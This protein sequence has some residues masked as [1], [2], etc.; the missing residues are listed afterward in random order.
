MGPIFG[1]AYNQYISYDANNKPVITTVMAD[2][3]TNKLTGW[4]AEIAE[5]QTSNPTK[6]LLPSP[7]AEEA[8][9]K[10][11]P[12]HKANS[13]WKYKLKKLLYDKA[14]T[15]K[16]SWLGSM[17]NKG[18]L[19]GGLVGGGAGFVGGALADLLASKLGIDSPVSFKVLGALGLGG[20]GA[21][22][23]HQRQYK[24]NSKI[25]RSFDPVDAN[26]FYGALPVTSMF[27][28]RAALYKNPR[29]FILE[30]LQAD[31]TL[32]FAEKAKL[33]AA[34]RNLD[35]DAALKLKELVRESLGTHT[36]KV[37]SKFIFNKPQAGALFG[38][39]IP[40]LGGAL[41]NT[42]Q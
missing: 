40:I 4:D 24:S 26:I 17:L 29:N 8:L 23:G 30:K 3:T 13:D 16:T 27:V 22:I 7:D 20:L 37:I 28:K 31:T 12:D 18:P 1:K 11:N 14:Y 10:A 25:I 21:F 42:L 38:G 9:I 36:G 6:F 5:Q 33:A 19:S 39:L 2:G 15:S 35:E 34:V 41:A 32:G